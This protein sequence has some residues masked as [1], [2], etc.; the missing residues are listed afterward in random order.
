[1]CGPSC[2]ISPR[3]NRSPS[4]PFSRTST[5]WSCR[6]DALA[7][8][9]L[10]RLLPRPVVAALHSW[11]T[12]R[13]RHG[14]S[15][16][17]VVHIAGRHRDR[18][19][20][21]RLARRPPRRAP[22]VEDD[23]CGRRRVAVGSVGVDAHRAGRGPRAVS[24]TDRRRPQRHGRLHVEPRPLL[25]REGRP[26]GRLRPHQTAGDRP[27]VR[28]AARGAG[29]G[30]R[31]GPGGGPRAGLRVLR[32]GHNRHHRRRPGAPVRRDRYGPRTCGTTWTRPTPARP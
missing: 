8:P 26:H 9:G 5:G 13:G 30:D 6:A 12:C 27:R 14:G 11:G 4:K 16:D 17:A 19:P 1:M 3:S 23:R 15:G 2:L 28:G 29:R 22:A 32:G 24:G 20:C 31:R 7:A 21:A 18:V 10:V 25:H